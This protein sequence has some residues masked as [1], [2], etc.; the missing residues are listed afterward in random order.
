MKNIYSI[1]ESQRSI[2]EI[3][4]TS[5]ELTYNCQFLD[6]DFVQEGFGDSVKKFVKK[7]IEFIKK[8][9]KFCKRV[10]KK[11][12]RIIYKRF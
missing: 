10:I 9:Y 6:V 7:V 4:V 3:N 1:I 8:N 11:S 12:I 5:Y 2:A